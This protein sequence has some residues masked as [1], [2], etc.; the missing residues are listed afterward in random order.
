MVAVRDLQETTR[1]SLSCS[2]VRTS[3]AGQQRSTPASPVSC[4][5][6]L[7]SPLP[8]AQRLLGRI[9]TIQNHTFPLFLAI[10]TRVH[11]SAVLA[12]SVGS[13]RTLLARQLVTELVLRAL[14]DGF[15]RT[16]PLHEDTLKFPLTHMTNWHRKKLDGGKFRERIQRDKI[17]EHTYDAVRSNTIRTNLR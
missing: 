6:V 2:Y 14:D 11:L 13:V 1:L 16:C 5:Q 15:L 17:Q 12:T 10:H 8:S 4:P 7:L 3:S 9:G